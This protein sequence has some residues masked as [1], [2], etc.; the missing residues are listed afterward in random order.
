MQDSSSVTDHLG[1]SKMR[2]WHIIVSILMAP[3]ELRAVAGGLGMRHP[4][5]YLIPRG[6]VVY[7]I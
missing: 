7:L 1:A 5:E 4:V 3:I 2:F 6:A